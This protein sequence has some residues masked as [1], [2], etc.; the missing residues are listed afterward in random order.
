MTGE[1]PTSTSRLP[2]DNRLLLRAYWPFVVPLIYVALVFIVQ[3]ADRLGAIDG[4]GGIEDLIYDDYDGAC[5]AL[6]GLNSIRGRVPS[7]VEHPPWL[8]PAEFDQ[9]LDSPVVLKPGYYL[10]YP[11]ATLL[12]FR[13]GY[14]LVP[15]IGT[16]PIPPAVLDNSHHCLVE[17]R[18]R[19]EAE[20]TLWR[21]FRTAL[22]T[23]TVLMAGCL[24][25][26]MAL[27]ARGYEPGGIL[28]G[29]A[30]LFILPAAL[31]FALMRF[32]VLP[33]LLVA[34][35]LFT[36]GRRWLVASAVLLGLGTM[37]KVYPV[38]L[39]PIIFRYLYDERRSAVAWAIAY[40][41]TMIGI[42]L[43]TAAV[44]D[45]SLALLPYR[46]QLARGLE[47]NMTLYGYILPV[48]L[49]ASTWL[50]KSFRLGSVVLAIVAMTWQRPRSVADL[51]RRGATVVLVFL[52]VQVFY[53]PQWLLWLLPLLAPLNYG[54]RLVLAGIIAL[55]VITY[56]S[57]PIGADFGTRWGDAVL[58]LLRLAVW[59][60][61]AL[62]I[63]RTAQKRDNQFMQEPLSI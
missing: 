33:A 29:P 18:P 53:S 44:F 25:L 48:E 19:T 43:T 52:A 55:D 1:S 31:Y 12:V 22:R 50:G 11:H 10:E 24:L 15:D 13:L 38:F 61:I 27:V 17:H 41:A 9:A 8:K 4:W 49:G 26:M 36:L 60:G 5:M 21:D 34:A 16:R 35:S 42:F 37:V 28:S 39:A 46:I 51:L 47:S 23:Y 58:V 62:A 6:R 54:N 56:L 30:W 57:F 40:L 45:W 63:W 2:S 7:Q 3:P 14:L 59:I 20:S 32:D